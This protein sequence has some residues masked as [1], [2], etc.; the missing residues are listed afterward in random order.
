MTLS[1]G[2]QSRLGSISSLIQQATD[3]YNANASV[4]DPLRNNAIASAIQSATPGGGAQTA[5]STPSSAAPASTG[6]STTTKVLIGVGGALV[7]AAV[8]YLAFGSRDSK[9]KP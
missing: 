7:V 4:L 5:V 8:A 3:I 6:M 1:Y 2:D 9:K